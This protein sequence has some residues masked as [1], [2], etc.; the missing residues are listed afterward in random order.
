MTVTL[1]T[2]NHL[3]TAPADVYSVLVECWGGG[4]GSGLWEIDGYNMPA[5]GGGGGAYARSQVSVVP[6]VAYYCIVGDGGEW[7]DGEDSYF[8]LN[9]S[10]YTVF[11]KADGGKRSSNSSD[12]GG[13]GG[14]T[15]GCIG[16]VTYKGGDGADG[17]SGTSRTGGG[18]GGAGSTGS[19]INGNGTNGGSGRSEYGGDGG[20]GGYMWSGDP[21]NNYGGGAGGAWGDVTSG[22]GGGGLIRLTYV[23]TPLTMPLMW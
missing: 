2:S 20:D 11:V 23:A 13:N 16:D 1:F 5:G 22:S 8:R 4:G 21:G 18:G 15:A 10:P 19:G 7:D 17:N 3:W 9:Q 6:G 12:A 14:H